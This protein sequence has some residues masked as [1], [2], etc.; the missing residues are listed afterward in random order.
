MEETVERQG[1]RMGINNK[2]EKKHKLGSVAIW[3]IVIFSVLVMTA[4]SVLVV[5]QFRTRAVDTYR[6]QAISYAKTASLFIDG[7]KVKQYLKTGETDEYYDEIKNYLNITQN[8]SGLKY[9][10]VYVPE[11]DDLMYIWDADTKENAMGFGSHEDYMKKG[12]EASFAAFKKNPEEMTLV[13][14]D[15]TYGFIVSAFY[16]IFDS[17]GEPIALVG[18][19]YSMPGLVS[20]IKTFLTTIFITLLL[21]IAGFTIVFYGFVDHAILHPIKKLSGATKELVDNLETD[22]KFEVDIHTHDEIEDLAHSFEKMY[23][24]IRTYISEV[25]AVTA[26]KERIGAELNV[27]TDIQSNMLPRIFPPFPEKKEFDIYATMNPAKEVGGD[28]YDF[29]LVDD[30]HLALVMADVSGKGVPAA[31]FMVIA[32]TLIKNQAQSGSSPKEVLEI[33]NNQLCENN[34]ADM[35]VTTWFGI[36]ETSTQTM[37]AANAG[38]EFPAIRR[39]GGEF[40]LYKDPHGLVLAYVEDFSYKE[41]EFKL[42]PGDTLFLYTDGVAEATNSSEE[43]YGTDRMLSALNKSADNGADS[44]QLLKDVRKDIDDFVKEASQFD[45]ITMLALTI[46]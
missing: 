24:E 45:D 30:D 42:A 13:S 41:Y 1:K 32:K 16:P 43:L 40:E 9:Y 26:E 18:V 38:H 6:S 20:S 10:Y 2:K 46:K 25:A 4:T 14:R 34:E 36:Y 12:K 33:V 23:S 7:D 11:E 8:N 35:F 39:K 29:F 37:R 17:T 3:A 31:L 28:F 44:H 22:E 21:V 27:A 5:Y 15:D 19:D